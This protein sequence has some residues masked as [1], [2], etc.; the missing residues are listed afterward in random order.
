[1][2]K[3]IKVCGMRDAENIRA[4]EHIARPDLMGFVFYPN[5]PRCVSF[6][7]QYLPNVP[8]VGVFVHPE[9]SNVLRIARLFGLWG[10]QLYEPT[11]DLCEHLRLYGL[12]VIVALAAKDNLDALTAPYAM[13]TDHFLFDTPSYTFGGSGRCFDHS[14]LASYHG[15]V[16]FLVSGGLNP[17]SIETILRIKHPRFEGVDLNSGFEAKI[18]IKEPTLLRDFISRLRNAWEIK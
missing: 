12:H 17:H 11:P 18:A 3:L 1:M 8:R 13:A 10:V 6:V 14:L 15:R 4:V 7:P 9:E 2:K 16:P 5:S